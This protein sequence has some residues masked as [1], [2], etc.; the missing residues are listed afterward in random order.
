M[1]AVTCVGGG[2]FDGDNQVGEECC[3]CGWCARDDWGCCCTFV[4]GDGGRCIWRRSRV[5]CNCDDTCGGGDWRR[6]GDG[7]G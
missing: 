1:S 5:H 4:D 2:L 6:G 3:F 7:D